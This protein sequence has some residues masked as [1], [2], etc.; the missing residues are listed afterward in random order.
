MS[1][2]RLLYVWLLIAAHVS[3]TAR[4]QVPPV[5]TQESFDTLFRELTNAGRWG[6]DDSLGTLNLITPAV[7]IA[8]ARNVR[9]GTTVSLAR[10]L[11]VGPTPNALMPLEVRYLRARAGEIHW[12]VDAPLLPMHGWAFS[13]I[14]ALA[15]A[16][17]R[18]S[19]YN[20]VPDTSVDTIRGA[21]RLAITAMR[22]GIVTRGVLIDVP[23]LRGVPFLDS[24]AVITVADIEAWEQRTGVRVQAGDVVLIRTGRGSKETNR[25]SWSISS[26]SAGPH[27]EIARWIRARDVAALGGDGGNERYPSLIPGVSEPLH[28]LA[29]VAM[30]MP[31]LDNLA[32]DEL[33]EVAASRNQW[34]FL[35]VVAPLPVPGGSGSLVNALAVF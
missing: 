30:G 25:G 24:N 27:P 32:L 15:H 22:Q 8:A 12:F 20:R 7:R 3:P 2:L 28:Q 35:L 23:R 33:S 19:L 16:A 14:D 21:A 31:V 1:R 11:I 9:S 10:P 29:L 18:G 17:F 34:T 26:V 4:A 6:R 13:H 5:M